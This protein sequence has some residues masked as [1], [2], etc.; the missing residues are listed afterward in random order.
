MRIARY[1]VTAALAIGAAV[2][3][4]YATAPHGPGLD[5]D[6]MSYVGAG[7]SLAQTGR[8]RIP[9]ADWWERDSTSALAQF[10][11]GLPIAIA[12]AIRAGETPVAAGR[13]VQAAAAAALVVIVVLLLDA[14]AGTPAG[15]LAALLLVAMPA[16][17][18]D[19]VRVLSEPLFLICLVGTLAAMV[20]R[21]ERPVLAGIGGAL[22]ELVR[23]AGISVGVAAVLWA[24]GRSG[25]WRLRVERALEAAL[26]VV[27]LHTWWAVRLHALGVRAPSAGRLQR[28]VPAELRA[29]LRTIAGWLAPALAGGAVRWLVAVLALAAAVWLLRRTWKRMPRDA[30]AGGRRRLFAASGLLALCYAA[31]L[32][33]SRAYVGGGIPFDARILSPLFVLAVVVLAVA[34]R[35]RWP[36]WSAGMRTAVAATV[37]A[38]AAAGMI[39]TSALVADLRSDGW[40]Y[41]RAQWQPSPE[42]EWLLT[43][44]RRYVLFSNNPMLVYFLSGR[45]SRELPDTADARE[46]GDFGSTL[47]ETGGA[48]IGFDEGYRR[49]EPAE[50]LAVVLR[51]RPIARFEHMLVW[52]PAGEGR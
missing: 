36:A 34:L 45:P 38:W 11:A 14:T 13:V 41:S 25:P 12:V 5:P 21:P 26:P 52:V 6:A 3:V 50:F 17:A 51:L 43:T 7:A 35:I 47:E 48:L 44:G 18:G 9:S 23:Y 20:R 24:F 40:G 32:L 15:A 16:L 31:V 1:A 2:S 10:P 4:L 27:A 37:A 30:R 29:G 49:M 8:L 19:Y 39:G 33:F 46:L 22:G 42:Q 28:G